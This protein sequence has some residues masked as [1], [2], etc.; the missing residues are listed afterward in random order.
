MLEIAIGTGIIAAA[1]I[2]CAWREY[3][4]DNPRDAKLLAAFGAG[5]ALA[6]AGML[7]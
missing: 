7:V 2:F 5:T 6:A 3:A 4:N 1:T